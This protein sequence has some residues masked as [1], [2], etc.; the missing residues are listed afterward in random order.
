MGQHFLSVVSLCV[1]PKRVLQFRLSAE[2]RLNEETLK[3]IINQFHSQLLHPCCL[4]GDPETKAFQNSVRSLFDM[5]LAV[6]RAPFVEVGSERYSVKCL[7]G[8]G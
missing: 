4:P 6:E 7:E 2:K 5:D 3:E 1:S 8:N